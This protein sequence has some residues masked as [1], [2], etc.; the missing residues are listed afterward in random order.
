MHSPGGTTA[1]GVAAEVG[2]CS[3]ELGLESSWVPAA[4]GVAGSPI[5]P[6]AAEV[7]CSECWTRPGSAE[8]VWMVLPWVPS[9]FSLPCEP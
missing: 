6:A 8:A 7:P 5:A 9:S 1:V 2:C 3:S 4:A